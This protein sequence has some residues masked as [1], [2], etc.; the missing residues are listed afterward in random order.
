MRQVYPKKAQMSSQVFIYIMAAL[1]IG[2]IVIVG[3]KGISTILNN[4]K[5]ADLVEFESGL[6]NEVSSVGF[7]STSLFE[8]SLP[9][10]I[11]EIC[12]IDSSDADPD[13]ADNN[14]IKNKIENN[15]EENVFLL[16]R[17]R[18]EHAYFISDIDVADDYLC[19]EEK[20]R[21]EIYLQGKGENICLKENR[22][23]D[24]PD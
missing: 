3:G 22:N 9:S 23:D 18:I 15:V 16:K 12:F 2:A 14:F 11:D 4:F 17:G 10:G 24:C 6:R 19:L 8:S 1:I 21:I 7:G 20:D 5:D 13:K